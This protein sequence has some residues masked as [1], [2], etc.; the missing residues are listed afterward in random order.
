MAQA[1]IT[2]GAR[3]SRRPE[4]MTPAQVGTIVMATAEWGG[5]GE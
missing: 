2:A 5:A 3:R 4:S 1:T